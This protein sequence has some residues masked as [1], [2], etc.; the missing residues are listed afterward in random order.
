MVETNV[1]LAW[2]WDSSA[3]WSCEVLPSCG[4]SESAKL[5]GFRLAAWGMAV[6]NTSCHSGAVANHNN[7]GQLRVRMASFPGTIES[8][9][10]LRNNR[11]MLLLLFSGNYN[12][13]KVTIN[14]PHSTLARSLPRYIHLLPR[15]RSNPSRHTYIHRRLLRLNSQLRLHLKYLSQTSFRKPNPTLNFT[16]KHFS[17]LT[18]L[19]LLTS[20][21]S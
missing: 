20:Q 1:I 14:K 4:P 18:P 17:L 7:R 6:G 10:L 9:L 16:P 21:L 12:T 8:G 11:A 5:V 15:S 13:S 3:S 19:S 2:R